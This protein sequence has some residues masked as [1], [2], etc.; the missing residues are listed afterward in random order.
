M[1]RQHRREE[2]RR[3][4][5]GWRKLAPEAFASRASKDEA[6][7]SPEWKVSDNPGEVGDI[8]TNTD[9]DG[10]INEA[11]FG[12]IFNY[13]T[14]ASLLNGSL[15]EAKQSALMALLWKHRE[16]FLQPKR[17]GRARN[18]RTIPIGHSGWTETKPCAGNTGQTE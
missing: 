4:L 17:L 12:E 2:E 18:A 14:P 16:I 13:H 7:K 6:E 5:E 1:N 10:D 3:G 8:R 9:T 15:S 11:E